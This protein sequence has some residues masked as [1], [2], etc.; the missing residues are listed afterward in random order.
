MP[1]FHNAIGADIR[2]CLARIIDL[3]L[4]MMR[5]IWQFPG[6]VGAPLIIP[7]L[8]GTEPRHY[9][10]YIAI[11][12]KL[13][14]SDAYPYPALSAGHS[15]LTTASCPLENVAYLNGTH[16]SSD[17]TRKWIESCTGET[18]GFEKLYAI[19]L[20]WANTSR[21]L[22]EPGLQSC[23]AF[24]L[25]SRSIVEKYVRVWCTSFESLAFPVASKWL[26]TK[27]L[28]LAYKP[29]HCIA[30]RQVLCLLI[31]IL[32]DAIWH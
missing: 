7:P 14:L 18:V 21:L 19:E 6:Q 3:S 30:Q 9:A 12:R 25:P 27:T 24:E 10:P 32:G 2:I 15:L 20:P 5:G 22:I 4:V 16:L 11:E 13:V 31:S 8:S 1:S 29:R 26:F 28:D 17:E 23:P